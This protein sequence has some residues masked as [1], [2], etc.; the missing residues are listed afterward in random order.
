MVYKGICMSG[1]IHEDTR[2]KMVLTEK[3]TS[4]DMLK[5]FHPSQL[6]K[7]FGG[8]AET[9]TNFW[10]PFVGKRFLPENLKEEV[11]S[12]EEYLRVLQDNP[13]LYRHPEHMTSPQSPSRD[14]VYSPS[15][16][17]QL[18]F[19]RKISVGRR[20][21]PNS[22]FSQAFSE[23]RQTAGSQ[24]TSSVSAASVYFDAYTGEDEVDALV[25]SKNAEIA[26]KTKLGVKIDNQ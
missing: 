20:G 11:M 23:R 7:R 24:F 14:F 10:P 22:H 5:D 25:A 1:F 16:P 15:F 3:T 21:E 4:E 13:E 6:E 8:Q 9:P 19:T 12:D 17:D 2:T 18:D 26:W